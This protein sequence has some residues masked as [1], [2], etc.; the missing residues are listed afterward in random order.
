MQSTAR[1]IAIAAAKNNAGINP[2]NPSQQ[3]PNVP[4]GLV[5]GGLEPVGGAV[6]ATSGPGYQ[7][8]SSWSG[9]GSLTQTLA[10]QQTTV[11]VNQNK[12]DAI[13]YWTSF[14]I[15]RQTGLDFNQSNTGSSA[16]TSIAFNIIQNSSINP[17]QILG[18]MKAQGQ[19]YVIDQ[20]GIIFGA[21]SQINVHT[22]VASSLPI[23]TNLITRGLLNNP[24]DQFLF[25]QLAIPAGTNGPTPAFT[26]PASNLPGGADGAVTVQAGA[27]ITAPANTD[28]TGGRVALIGPDVTNNGTIS[29]PDGQTILA[30][31][32]QVGFAANPSADATLR[33]LDTYIGAVGSYGDA[34]NNGLIE[35]NQGDAT[36]AGRYVNQMGVI[37]ST[38]S[39]TLNGRIDLD[40]SYGTDVLTIGNG[41]NAK[42]IFVPTAT[43]NVTLGAG[44]LSDILPEL[45][46]PAAVVGTELALSS[47]VNIEGETI[48]FEANAQLLAPN[49]SVNITAGNWVQAGS[50]PAV[51]IPNSGQIYLDAGATID[52]QGSIVSAPVS[53]NIVSAELL[54]PELADSPLQ[55]NGALYGQT[56]QVDARTSGVYNG[57]EWQ[58][59]P[60]A[61]VTGYI[62]LIELPVGEL[63]TAG[64]SV[65]LTAGGSV[66]MQPTSQ[67]NV[68]GGAI[69]YQG[70][71]VQTT[72]LL[73]DGQII[74]I[75]DAT[76]D[77][78][79]QGI[80]GKFTVSSPKWGI[81]KSFT[82]PL[83]GGAV[84][85]DSY[86]QGG[87]GGS[88]SISAPSMALDGQLVGQTTIGP[89]QLATPPTASSLALAFQSQPTLTGA[90][91]SPTPPGVIFSTET[92]EPAAPTFAE[93]TADDPSAPEAAWQKEVVLSPE[94]FT[95][96]GFGSLTVKDGDGNI[97]VPTGV[98]LNAPAFGSISLTAANLY[99]GGSITAPDGTL[100]FTVNYVSPYGAAQTSDRGNFVMAAGASLSTAG[101]IVDN[102]EFSPTAETLH[103]ALGGGSITIDAFSADLAAGSSINVSGGVM[104][105]PSGKL[106]YGNGGTLSIAAGQDPLI[107]STL[108]G[109]LILDATLTG[110]SGA[111]G[112]T[113]SIQAPAIQIGAGTPAD[114]D[115]LVLAPSFFDQGGFAAFSLT[116]LGSAIGG[117]PLAGDLPAV[118]ITPN[119][120]ISPV[121][122]SWLGT[123]APLSADGITL[124][125]TL[126]PEAQRTPVSLSLSAPGVVN[127]T[128]NKQVVRGDLIMGN[129]ASI[130][131]DAGGIVS[132]SAQTATVL[133]SIDAPGGK[134]TISG[135]GDS[136]TI[137]QNI[138]TPLVTVY[139]GPN[140][141]LSTAGTTVLTPD[142]YGYLT[143][144]VL[145]G[146]SIKVSGNIVA[147]AGSVLDVSG[148]SGVLYLPESETTLSGQN[149]GS[150]LGAPVVPFRVDSNGGSITLAGAQE[151]FSDA[152]LIGTAG[153]PAA[154][155][156]SLSIA[157]GL[158]VP[159]GTAAL[160]ST[161]ISLTITQGGVPAPTQTGIGQSVLGSK[162][163]VL[164]QTGGAFIAANDFLGGGFDNVTLG[165]SVQFNGSVTIRAG[166]ELSVGSGG[167]ISTEGN[168]NLIAPYVVLGLP[169]PGPL[170]ATQEAESPFNSS[171]TIIDLPPTAGT[172]HL[173]VSASLIDIGTL[174]LQDIDQ[175]NFIAT[176]G[177]IRGDGT[178]D[179]EG[180]INMTAGQI[181]PAT[182]VTF[183]IAAYNDGSTP[184]TI[185]IH[186]S[187]TRDLPLSAGGTLNLY[188][189]VINQDG[190][191]RAPLGTINLGWNSTAG[192]AP[193]DP[194]TGAPVN[195]TTTLTLGSQS[196]TSVSAVDP[197]NGQ[198]LIIPYGYN[199]TG[200]EWIDPAGND[201][202]TGGVPEKAI[203]LAGTQI[204]DKAGSVV[205]LNGGGDLSSY[206]FISGE[207][208]STDFLNPG[209]QYVGGTTYSTGALVTYKGNTYVADQE[210]VNITPGVNQYWSEVPASYAV[211]PG[212]QATYAPYAPFNA[213]VGDPGYVS[214]K[215]QVGEQVYLGAGSGL[216]AG[217]YTLLPAR[218]ALLPGAY[219]VTPESGTP[220]VGQTEPDGSSIVSGYQFNGFSNPG[221]LT[222]AL[223]SLFQVDSPSVNLSR[224]Q[225]TTFTADTYLAQ[226]A[227]KSKVAAPLL[228]IDAGQLNLNATSAL[229]LQ[230]IVDEGAPAGGTAGLVDI[231][232]SSNI[233]ITN[234][235]TAPAG[236]NGLV[237]NATELSSF[238]AADLLIGG[239]TTSTT[240]GTTVTVDTNNITI[241]QGARLSGGDVILVSNGGLTVDSGASITAKGPSDDLSLTL[242]GNGTFLRVS[243]DPAA[244]ITRTGVT[245][246]GSA[247]LTV[248]ASAK[249]KGAS[250]ILDSSN[251]SYLDPT[252]NLAAKDV[253]LDAGL[254]S[255]V[256]PG[257]AVTPGGLVL[258]GNALQQIETGVSGLTLLSYS[259]I[260]LYGSATAPSK[261]TLGNLTLSA[262]QIRTFN[263]GSSG[264]VTLAANNITVDG[265]P[266]ATAPAP[267]SAANG[268][269]VLDG[270][271]IHLGGAA[272]EIDSNLQLNGSGGIIG[273]GSG[274]AGTASTL[275]VTGNLTTSAPLITAAAAAQTSITSDGAVS[276]T[277]AGSNA[278]KVSGGL[279]ANLS[280]TGQSITD[281][282]NISAPSGTISLVT[283]GGNLVIGDAA[284]TMLSVAGT[285]KTLVDAI[286][287]TSG[288]TINL[289][290]NGSGN[291][292]LGAD[293]AINVSAPTG[294]ASAGTLNVTVPGGSVS[295]LGTLAGKGGAG[296]ASGSFSLDAGSI[297][298][299]VYNGQTYAQGNVDSIDEILNAGGFEQSI[300]IR[301]Q[302]DIAVTL[303]GAVTAASYNLSADT[304]SITVLGTINASDVASTDPSGNAISTGGSITLTAAGNVTIGSGADLNVSAQNF[305]NAGKGGS[306]TLCA[307]AGI[308]NGNASTVGSVDVAAGST[309]NLSVAD[310]A[311]VAAEVEALLKAGQ[312]PAEITADIQNTN[313]GN[314]F[315]GT[316]LIQTPQATVGSD[317]VLGNIIGAAGATYGGA[318]VA[319]PDA[320]SIIVEGYK[321]YNVSNYSNTGVITSALQQQ[322]YNDGV[323]FLG[324]NGNT[325]SNYTNLVTSLVG[326]NADLGTG[327]VVNQTTQGLTFNVETGAE[328]I[329][330]N[331][332]LVLGSS[333]SYSSAND[334]D[335]ENDRFGPNGTAGQLTL[336]AS[337]NLIFN[338]T[339]SDG[340]AGAGN[341]AL[342]LQQNTA[343]PANIQSWS[344]TLTAGANLAAVAPEVVLTPAQLASGA[345]SLELG[346]NDATP[347][348]TSGV[349][350]TTANVLKG[351][352][353]VI[354]TGAGSIDISTGA[355]V[356]LLNQ[357]ASIYTAG[358]Q[359]L[360]PMMGGAF[361]IPYLDES[362]NSKVGL[363]AGTVVSA[364]GYAPQY[365]VAGGS[366]AL[367]AQGSIEHLTLQNGS[368]V[369][370]SQDE[371]PTDWLY[372]R[373]DV[374]STG[375]FDNNPNIPSTSGVGD[376]SE[377][378]T[379]W[380]DF[381][382]FFEG[383]GALG[384]GNVTMT[385]GANISNVDA[386]IPTNAR[387]PGINTTTNANLAPNT[388]SLVE[389]GGGDLV[390]RAGN[391]IN[392][393]VYYVENGQGTLSA[394]NQILTNSTRA[395]VGGEGPTKG[396]IV[397]PAESWLPTTLFAGDA[398]FNI[399][400]G[401][402]ITLGPV[403]NP[404]LLPEGLTNSIW[405]KTYFSTY[406]FNDSVNVSSLG[407]DI[408]F[409]ETAYTAKGQGPILQV[410]LQN[411][412]ILVGQTQSNQSRAYYQPWLR[413]NETSVAPFTADAELMPPRLVSTAFAGNIN[414]IG[415]LLLSPS[416]TGSID[417][418]ASGSV[419]GFQLLGQT[420]VGANLNWEEATIDVSDS[421][422]ASIP[423]DATPIGYQ[424]VP[425]IGTSA[426]GA[427]TTNLTVNFLAPISDLF[428]VTNGGAAG[429]IETEQA[430]HD[431][432]ILHPGNS[433][434]VELYAAG[435]DITGVTLYSPTETQVVAGQDITDVSFYLQNDNANAVSV[436][437]AGG[438]II[439]YDPSSP[440]RQPAQQ[441]WLVCKGKIWIFEC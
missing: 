364:P 365:S 238:G 322:I 305:N 36:I 42:D 186:G 204:V 64:G 236:S 202:N 166:G 266:N 106:T 377:S 331:G 328:I 48:H 100:D 189:S 323:A 227:A 379:W 394:G 34:T 112:G 138:T 329:N 240:A 354:R 37:A 19:V 122:E 430:L 65:S 90:P 320:A 222:G 14:N 158:F 350:A 60:L 203:N 63:T 262:A 120:V 35:V 234:G 302:T 290:A 299:V 55:R 1:A 105:N 52:V 325:T 215:L 251:A 239:Y 168:V 62:D 38:T 267:G 274:T 275:L 427:R 49:A 335:L 87:N 257:T 68:S 187:G 150:F 390:A 18:S 356:E 282:G 244:A 72:Y 348:S 231:N 176:N 431:P 408:T 398:S 197:A 397:A 260:D 250:V 289:T 308:V 7:V 315:A 194:I 378:T 161:D 143:G 273:Q 41:S 147:A 47:E 156:G 40:A 140:S 422:P 272:L 255:I 253:T 381:S 367:A 283:T 333:T 374:S 91:I 207:G 291:V 243:N 73:Y 383:V 230:G 211:I 403:A 347:Y 27:Q 366:V 372:R 101:L 425:G 235:P 157:S 79:Y 94:L 137:F 352:Y 53:Q 318:P 277:G 88:I 339:L 10:N 287:Y 426:V 162:G 195:S 206:Q 229:V 136:S 131:T 349:I 326:A 278:V 416:P 108:G 66:V 395:P 296:G 303:D 69:N 371:L 270:G 98:A 119:T 121:V 226:Q 401:G 51:L 233:D 45:S 89:R 213:V 376:P 208:G 183:T 393:G 107:V 71:T 76:P 400:A 118:V 127:N 96:D 171:G 218:Y 82:T 316:L 254:I 317:Q 345:G 360:D 263:Q 252:A 225:Y 126:F 216:S 311:N 405:Y 307:G 111:T 95:Q 265:G 438:D 167:V 174:S 340:F 358:T 300:S 97:T 123:I 24:D 148:A 2:N 258:S 312:T 61:N 178:L 246:G 188:A 415:N 429:T 285:E 80:L 396:D 293:G 363:G 163:Q 435:G 309:I 144:N 192:K 59:T 337:G 185:T 29:T 28:S 399:N 23:N 373:G 25:S 232:T 428:A 321:V 199:P 388:A 160:P 9:V 75:A 223:S 406:G 343:L 149:A 342:L 39:V 142:V 116:G 324:A 414:I 439:A 191:L 146:G 271:V 92:P 172:G 362:N 441:L 153:G 409:D 297:P 6:P 86:A 164:S 411:M 184:G 382:N 125:P 437:S 418:A 175:A 210:S 279:G 245:A 58:G 81:D 389:L 375:V 173:T 117:Q 292:T 103:E 93:A 221:G 314:D 196:I 177:D 334:W 32:E 386:V 304:G 22:L 220:A 370:D 159:A 201:I 217:V 135:A 104:G 84:Y 385:A 228:P 31:G 154:Y 129:G 50:S 8:P 212:Y 54:G 336:R 387:M 423:G 198:A 419:I 219:L 433:N 30:A 128:T 281:D 155:G 412:D 404:F 391:D 179:V 70:G 417:L 436:I 298:S 17:T 15:G 57:V 99:I 33:G 361:S 346:I 268:T 410:W 380:V 241:E 12:Q 83:V 247:S 115:A 224:G 256:E 190:V 327:G 78:V 26:P 46:S 237:L 21:G 432:N 200:T 165:G 351:Y 384:G 284:Q 301:D 152:T 5:T 440:A 214:N 67:V 288:G 413:I 295:L 353:Q 249:L 344:Y 276:L 209:E 341:T 407:G 248:D 421:N 85:Q 109:K 3:L 181:Y 306:V 56:I 402:S 16:D 355:N 141:I 130:T 77:L 102:L 110:Y 151:L 294:G 264:S 338:N 145:P 11:T 434:P 114:P 4:N 392:A 420:A 134:I 357:F 259:S 193:T 132:I 43:G 133:G 369:M 330:P 319:V 180:Q 13:L 286:R 261:T 139:L 170:T 280:I 424:E 74:N 20:N 359:V 368:L 205:D 182:D 169:F 113:L 44:S 124:T 269:L 332:N 310:S 313:Y 242:T